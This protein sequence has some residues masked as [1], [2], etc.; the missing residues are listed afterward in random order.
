MSKKKE[1]EK[2]DL[3]E[4]EIEDLKKRLDEGK[5]SQEET[6]L[7]KNVLKGF[8]WL[9]KMLQAKKLS[10]KKLSRLFGVKT[11]KDKKPKD[12]LPPKKDKKKGPQ[13]NGG[14]RGKDDYTGAKRVFHE[15]EEL[16]H[17][18]RCPGCGR[19]NL[20]EVE[21]GSFVNLKGAPP[22]QATVHQVQKFRCSTCGHT[23]EAETPKEVRKQKYDETADVAIALMKYG[24]GVPFYRQERWQEMMGVPVPSSTAWDRIEELASSLYPVYEKLVE[25]ASQSH[26]SYIDDTTARV[27]SFKKQLQE[28]GTERCGLYTTG[29]SAKLSDKI[30]NLFMTGNRHAGEN[31]DRLLERRREELSPMVRMS[32]ALSNNK[33]KLKAVVE[34][35]CLVHARRQFV[36]AK[37]E[38]RKESEYVIQQLS[39][40]FKNEERLKDRGVTDLERLDYHQRKSQ[41]ILRKLRRWCLKKFYLRKIEPNS[42]LGGAIQYLL[43]HWKGL[44]E[45][46][47]TPGAPIENN[48][49]ERLLKSS[50][51]HRKNSLF[52]RTHLGAYVGDVVMSLIE[53]CRAMNKNPFNYLVAL[54]RN[55]KTVHRRPELCLPWNYEANL[56]SLELHSNPGQ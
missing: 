36:D 13:S 14:R 15:H 23:Y 19:G 7:L 4:E 27:T 45:F 17:G 21:P 24:T 30:I 35:L 56:S 5:L 11:E 20:Y 18:D 49:A 33:P 31:L 37:V 10:I 16:S 53:T 48:V 22:L 25:Q 34:C 50:I 38:G 51:L 3:S 55:R 41:K 54:H 9:N 40:I 32:D 2:I 26:V 52:Y 28:E 29:I 39:K 46:L 12:K 47:R 44:T 42:P 8:V 43:K 1:P 6:E